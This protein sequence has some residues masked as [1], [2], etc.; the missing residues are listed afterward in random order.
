MEPTNK[1]T[2][3]LSSSLVDEFQVK[4]LPYQIDHFLRVLSIL[5]TEHGYLDTSTMGLG[6]THI[7]LAV[8]KSLGLPLLIVSPLTMINTWKIKAALYQIPL[9][10]IITYQSL[11]GTKRN[12][13]LHG[14][15]QCSGDTYISTPL[16]ENIIRGGVLLVFDEIQYIKNQTA[17]LDASHALVKAIVKADSNSKV[18]L[19]SALPGE[20][21]QHIES[22]LKMLGII[23]SD[24]LYLYNP[25]IF[26]YKLEGM[27]E[28][29]SKCKTIDVERTKGILSKV[30]L[31]RKTISPTILKLYAE[32][33]KDI[34]SS[35]MQETSD[36]Q[37]LSDIQGS[38]PGGSEGLSL[39]TSIQKDI[40]TG[41]YNISM[42]NSQILQRGLRLLTNVAYY[43]KDNNT[44]VIR[45]GFSSGILIKSLILMEQARLPTFIRLAKET[46]EKNPQCK[47]IIYLNFLR[48][49]QILSD[50]LSQY[51]PLILTGN[52]KS[53]ERNDIIDKFQQNNLNHRLLIANPKVG[54][55]GI[56]LDDR[57]G[58]FRRYVYINP[59]YNFNDLHQVTGRVARLATTKSIPVIRFVFCKG[60]K[61]ELRILDCLIRKSQVARNVIY[62]DTNVKFPGDYE[63]YEEPLI[64]I[65]ND[66]VFE[67]TNLEE[68]VEKERQE[69]E[70]NFEV[71]IEITNLT[72]TAF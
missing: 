12:P 14:L 68:I 28:V 6:K 16:W 62:D 11:R 22:I 31:D 29:I 4:L 23:T 67:E 21:E 61:E 37:V 33:L 64:D 69:E 35:S 9:I 60:S 65:E 49:I 48:H 2:D 5:K 53:Y 70:L 10:G 51:N 3:N 58:N 71:P 27:Q 50:Y 56:S 7:A 45:K 32:I 57:D 26:S 36:L 54:G 30:I 40:K 43:R 72:Q 20:K 38:T 24:R 47:V 19:L 52:K 15:L 46:L 59:S 63:S 34:V 25:G 41:Y 17:Q 18:A 39:N 55:I 13:P 8:A 1:S 44:I 66:P 42:K